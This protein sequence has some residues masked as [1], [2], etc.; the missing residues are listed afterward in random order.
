MTRCKFCGKKLDDAGYCTNEKCPES[1]RAK[2]MQAAAQEEA[3]ENTTTTGEA[4]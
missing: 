1:I 3:D 2:I 4:K